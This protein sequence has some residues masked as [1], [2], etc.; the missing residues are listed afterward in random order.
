M[1]IHLCFQF[2]YDTIKI[3][4]IS[5]TLTRSEKDTMKNYYI[6]IPMIINAELFES[7]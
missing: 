3:K 4:S 7:T 5:F 1:K 6:Q 2:N